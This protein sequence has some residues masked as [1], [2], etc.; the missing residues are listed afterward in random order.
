MSN[1]TNAGMG[2]LEHA[3]DPLE[4]VLAGASRLVFVPFALKDWDAYTESVRDALRGTCEVRGI[5][6]L[7]AL[8][9]MEADAF[10]VGGGNTFRLLRELQDRGLVGIL[11]RRVGEGALYVGASAGSVIASPNIRTTNDMPIVQPQSFVALGFLGFQLNCHYPDEPSGPRVFMGE[12]RDERLREFLEENRSQV[13]CLREGAWLEIDGSVVT[14]GG[15]NGGRLFEA[16]R[17]ARHLE[18]G[19][20]SMELGYW[21]SPGGPGI[22]MG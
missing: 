20:S 18:V 4:R 7:S 13:V 19:E 1:S 17:E 11:R 10:Y 6:T 16:G 2:L 15:T 12:T 9:A 5:H 21:R 14:L 3:R 22:R 8:E